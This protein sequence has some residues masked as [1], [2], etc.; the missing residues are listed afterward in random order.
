MI[1]KPTAI[2]LFSGCGGLTLGLKLA[3]FDV[4]GAVEIDAL[5]SETYAL[6]HPE[7]R[8]WQT[9]IR[10]LDPES[11][12]AA[13]RLEPGELDLLAGCPP[14][15]GFS[16][17]RTLNG[18]REVADE[19]NDLLFDFLRFVY[20]MRPRNVMMENVPP[21]M[22]DRRFSRMRDE[23]EAAGYH[24]T[25]D[26]R[27]AADYG[28]PQRRR[29]FIMVASLSETPQLA[30]PSPNR[31]TVRQAI[32][33]LPCAGDSGDPLHDFPER[34][35]E[36]VHARIRSIPLDGGSRMDL[37]LDQQLPCHQRSNGFK[38][39]YGRMAWDDVAP[40]ITG[41]CIKP[42]KGRFIHPEEHRAITLREAAILQGFPGDYHFSL[43]RGKHACAE[44]IGNALPPR[45][46]RQHAAE[47]ICGE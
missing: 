40:T 3:G 8:L 35:S 32:R 13:L 20:A 29:R 22:D 21:L 42:S 16:S 1:Q 47:L 44:M 36:A 43:A 27:D 46:V 14:C 41:G 30:D 38:D 33:D 4:V 26:V 34:R 9:D 23:L 45:F 25:A 5:A 11:V 28:V 7:V 10:D 24:V 31:V 2:D 19:R 37:P 12:L 18:H 17:I 15:Q 6:N 39:V